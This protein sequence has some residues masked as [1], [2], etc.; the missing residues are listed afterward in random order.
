MEPFCPVDGGQV[1]E[2]VNA[3][4]RL[5]TS[6]KVIA[7]HNIAFHDRE[8]GMVHQVHQVLP[9]APPKVVQ[10]HHAMTFVEKAI[11]QR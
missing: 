2:E 3:S 9:F 8:M 10:H 5:K 1:V 6:L 7:A 4:K 11:H